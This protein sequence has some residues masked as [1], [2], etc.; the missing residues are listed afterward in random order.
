MCVM[1]IEV[2]LVSLSY[3]FSESVSVDTFEKI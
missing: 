2:I 3:S 1:L